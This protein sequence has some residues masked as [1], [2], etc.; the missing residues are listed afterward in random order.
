MATYKNGRS[1]SPNHPVIGTI[2]DTAKQVV[3]GIVH[4][5]VNDAVSRS[6]MKIIIPEL[7]RSVF[8]DVN[9]QDFYHAEDALSAADLIGSGKVQPVVG[10]V[11]SDET[12]T[13]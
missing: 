11:P 5:V 8:Q 6:V 12:K 10:A 4:S 13:A 9:S 3:S 2:G 7:G 1:V